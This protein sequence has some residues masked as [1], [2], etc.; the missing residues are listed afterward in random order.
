MC[1]RGGN[2]KVNV[3]RL[4]ICNF[5][6]SAETAKAKFVAVNNG[7]LYSSNNHVVG[8]LPKSSVDRA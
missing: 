8:S 6:S 3:T 1:V 7:R 5:L 4:T 2:G